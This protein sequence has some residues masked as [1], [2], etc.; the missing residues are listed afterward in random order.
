MDKII[1]Y[2][3]EETD[4][5]IE[6]D[7][8]NASMFADQYKYGLGLIERMLHAKCGVSNIIAFCGDRGEGKTSC[9]RSFMNIIQNESS[10][11]QLVKDSSIDVQ[12][13]DVMDLIDPAF[14]DKKHN[15]IEL[16][17]GQMYGRLGGIDSDDCKY[18]DKIYKQAE[19]LK[20]FKKVKECLCHL[21]K[22][23][24]EL[25]DPFEELSSLTAGVNLKERI[26]GLICQYLDY[27]RKKHLVIAIDDLDLNMTEAYRMA[28]QIRKYLCVKKCTILIGLKIDQ[29]HRVIESSISN[30]VGFSESKA[31]DYGEMASKY[32][33]KLIPFGNRIIMPH[34]S[35]L[36]E[37]KL[38]IC[39]HGDAIKDAKDL[40]MVKDVVT[41]QIFLKTRYLFYNGKGTVS[42]IVPDNLR[43]LRLLLGMLFQM[44][45]FESNQKHASNKRIFKAY[46]FEEWTRKLNP[47]D[48]NFAKK[49]SNISDLSR[50][51]SY[52]LSYL[53]ERNK[54]G[55]PYRDSQYKDE[56]GEIKEMYLSIGTILRNIFEI[57]HRCLDLE[58]NKLL[59][60]LRS[61][62][63]FKLYELYDI[64]TENSGNIYPKPADDEE[65]VIKVDAFFNN[66]NQLQKFVN[67]SY[68]S[69][70][71]SELIAK[72]LQNGNRD[73]RAINGSAL[74]STMQ[75][76]K[77][78]INQISEKEKNGDIVEI[79]DD[80]KRKFKRCEFFILTT[81]KNVM[82]DD[83]ED[84]N[85]EW[86]FSTPSFL[87]IY[88]NRMGGYL[89]DMLAPFYN[90][91]N[92]RYAYQRFKDIAD[93][94]PFALSHDW[95][96]LRQMMIKVGEQRNQKEL[97]EG[98]HIDEHVA[99]HVLMSDAVIRNT[100]IHS[101]VFERL[102]DNRIKIKDTSETRIL[103]CLNYQSITHIGMHTYSM[104]DNTPYTITF[105]FLNALI[106]YLKSEDNE[107]FEEIMFTGK[108]NPKEGLHAQF[109]K[110]MDELSSII[111]LP[112]KGRTIE[113][114]I[115]KFL[116]S[117][118]IRLPKGY[119]A[120]ITEKDTM[121]KSL[122]QVKRDLIKK[123]EEF[124]DFFV[125]AAN[126]T[127]KI[128][129]NSASME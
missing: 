64:V 69:Y 29:L 107:Q 80:F 117:K 1:F 51:N 5:V 19:L 109:D 104:A 55:L 72:S 86:K 89:F 96:I 54:G 3:G 71:P 85:A 78:I 73:M 59:F 13:I 70:N 14:F 99:L 44:Q 121:Y 39:N 97:V 106:D 115:R 40:K 103:L 108:K 111:N 28:E 77:P 105:T 88:N 74:A 36:W 57:E 37:T 81:L 60:F 33:V 24:K 17:L 7:D 83:K 16:V 75:E 4:I 52:V 101:A 100:D 116:L 63:S 18:S 35:E 23:R 12:A 68:F 43:D 9:M 6:R 114:N 113:S 65:K 26:E 27:M 95:S 25:Y 84:P 10:I 87:T 2:K 91:T 21:E 92:L 58:L 129:D 47:E 41:E 126:T 79:P 46:F 122:E 48:R 22:E 98:K 49:L 42:P 38:Q 11:K 128:N 76:I 119:F 66:V 34:V 112:C 124:A 20:E 90:V 120:N 118:E 30:E 45:D 127:E 123:G 110:V 125:P 53:M 62:Y 8:L 32:V 56:I 67:G 50:I 82:Y 31:F 93:L 102:L 15:V 94:Y 61:Y